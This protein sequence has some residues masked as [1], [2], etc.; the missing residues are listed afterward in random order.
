MGREWGFA[1]QAFE[2]AKRRKSRDSGYESQRKSE[3]RKAA[4]SYELKGKRR[5]GSE[6]ATGPRMLAMCLGREEMGKKAGNEKGGKRRRKRT[7]GPFG[8]GPREWERP[9][10]TGTKQ[11]AG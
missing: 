6:V 8:R 9:P 5:K 3:S 11:I 7:R 10:G 1:A 4:Q 2:L